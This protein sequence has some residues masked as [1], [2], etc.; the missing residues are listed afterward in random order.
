VDQ[1]LAQYPAQV[2]SSV[3]GTLYLYLNTKTPPFDD[4]RV[5]RAVDFAL[6]RN[7]MLQLLG[8]PAVAQITCQILPPNTPGYRPYC[9]YTVN[10]NPGGTW[11]GPDLAA[12]RD[13]VAASGPA[14]AKVSVWTFGRFNGLGPYLKG[15]FGDLGF[16]ADLRPFDAPDLFF[17]AIFDPANAAKVQASV[18][19]WFPDFP[20]AS[21]MFTPSF[22]CDDPGNFSHLCDDSMTA[23]IDAAQALQLSDPGS[24]GEA[25]AAA[26]RAV[27]DLAPAAPFANL[28]E[29][30]LVSARVGNFQHH[31]EWLILYDQLWVQ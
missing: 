4:V 13:L 1:L 26:D 10:P 6:D 24:A 31:P 21:D 5:R 20:S 8:G 27:V 17:Q 22:Q 30:E 3:T 12:A 23:K 18:V 29:A 7:Q 2:H 11:T 9:P 14:G 25:W 16:A 28:R 15:L 19:A